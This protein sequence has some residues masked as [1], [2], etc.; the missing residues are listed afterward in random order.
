MIKRDG[1]M[2]P[3][4]MKKPHQ[5]D[6]FISRA[7]EL[8]FD[9]I[10]FTDH[11]PF[12]VTGDEHDRIPF[13]EVGDYCKAVADF[14]KKYED[15]IR[16]KTGIEIDFHPDCLDEIDEVL[17]CGKFDVILGSSHL[18][19]AGFGVPFGRITETEYAALVLEN[20]LRAAESGLFHVMTHL[21]VY[22]WVFSEEMYPTVPD[23]FDV[24]RHE[25][26]LRHIFRVMEKNDIALEV[27]A[28]P[29]YKKFDE[30][31]AYPEKKILSV[32]ED[33]KLRLVYGSD[34]HSADKVG[35]EYDSI[36]K[37]IENFSSARA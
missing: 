12:T 32:A 21:D 8:G 9:E 37:I 24:M 1:H 29:I 25:D 31:G 10:V 3:N 2:H 16:I 13:G 5:G 20:Y 22:R 7:I 4:I 6:E 36:S 17:S 15:R 34:A 26:L 11:M 19:I 30:L 35:F 28:A 18:N 27:N 33:Y 14:A 23:G